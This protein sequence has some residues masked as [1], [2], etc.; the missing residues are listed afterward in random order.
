MK[1][2]IPRANAFIC[3]LYVRTLHRLF[4]HLA[5]H[6]FIVIIAT[7]AKHLRSIEDVIFHIDVAV[8]VSADAGVVGTGSGQGHATATGKMFGLLAQELCWERWNR[9]YVCR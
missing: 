5:K 3:P 6:S 1:E 4:F 2:F 7:S 8:P 9:W